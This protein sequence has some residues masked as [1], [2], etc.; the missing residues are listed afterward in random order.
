MATES[1]TELFRIRKKNQSLRN[2]SIFQNSAKKHKLKSNKSVRNTE[3]NAETEK[4][5]INN[6][7]N[8]KNTNISTV[9][10]TTIAWQQ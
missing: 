2:P 7:E 8:Y 1:K 9:H 5:T 10:Q 4:E 3:N 6:I